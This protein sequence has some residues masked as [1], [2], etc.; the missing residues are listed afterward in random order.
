M[1]DMHDLDD[2]HA[3]KAEIAELHARLERLE[4]SP[5]EGG[6]GSPPGPQESERRSSRRTWISAAGASAVGAALVM[7]PGRPVAAADPNDV[8]KDADNLVSGTTSLT[9]G[10]LQVRNTGGTKLIG[11]DGVISAVGSETGTF[12]A[13]VA[14][15]RRPG[16]YG[17]VAMAD[18]ANGARAQLHLEASGDA[19]PSGTG[20]RKGELSVDSAG[21]LWFATEFDGAIVFREVCG[22]TT[23]GAF[24]AIAPVRVYDSRLGAIPDSG[25][26]AP[27][28]DRTISIKDGF[29]LAGVLTT[30]DAVPEG[31]TAIAFNVTVTATTG[32]NFLSIVPGDDASFTTSS[33][34]WSAAAQSI[35]NGLTVGLNAARQVKIFAGDQT[36]ST[37]VIIDVL[38]Y[39]K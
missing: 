1:D 9:G 15:T 35:A 12:N 33:I 17:I 32:P 23:A 22:P 20:H 14:S 38:G 37:H 7:A 11:F 28:T 18:R 36:G 10:K 24:H 39:Y 27:N 31:A 16:G 6:G 2:I 8:V 34:N 5:A 4:G 30:P 13:V 3:L 29:D 25:I 26:F 21:T 19:P